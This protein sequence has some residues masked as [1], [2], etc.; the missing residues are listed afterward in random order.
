MKKIL[1]IILVLVLTQVS[2]S[3]QFGNI[4]S[5]S[6]LEINSNLMGNKKT[7]DPQ[8]RIELGESINDNHKVEF[9]RPDNGTNIYQIIATRNNT[10][11]K[12]IDDSGN[13]IW[14]KNIVDFPSRNPI[15]TSNDG[16]RIVF[17]NTDH[18]HKSIKAI[19]DSTGTL[20]SGER[21]Y[22]EMSPSGNYFYSESGIN[23]FDSNLN[24]IDTDFLLD[25]LN[26]N[27][28]PNRYRFNLN[29]KENDILIISYSEYELSQESGYSI[30][31]RVD[32]KII[33]DWI[34]IID[35]KSEINL[36]TRHTYSKNSD[37]NIKAVFNILYHDGY[38]LY[39]YMERDRD[40]KRYVGGMQTF[41]LDLEVN[42][43]VK[44]AEGSFLKIGVS[45]KLEQFFIVQRKDGAIT[46][47]T[48]SKESESREYKLNSYRRVEDLV[49]V[50]GTMHICSR[51]LET[52]YAQRIEELNSNGS[53][54][55]KYSGWLNSNLQGVLPIS[56]KEYTI[57]N[58]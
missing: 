37:E 42:T 30:N 53:L 52:N 6:S 46:L 48:V 36:Y 50:D 12:K 10:T 5:E 9:I 11:L 41:L 23:L 17:Y 8:E 58:F 13:V 1:S 38:V 14:E 16:N 40:T 26:I 18:D 34:S 45:N 29:I 47:N 25:L 49:L 54:E 7:I 28:D 39:S 35:L 15:K 32:R 21:G 19:Y 57:K 3:A 55:L 27:N 31:R 43:E 56:N 51:V 4:F 22:L 2:V 44:V 24:P 33:N 20:K